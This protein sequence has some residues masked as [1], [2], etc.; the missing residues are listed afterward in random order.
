M[1][2]ELK[3]DPC[4]GQILVGSVINGYRLTR[5]IGRGGMGS[6][7]AAELTLRD[8]SSG[9]ATQVAVKVLH[10]RLAAVDPTAV[11]RFINEA[12]S[13][14]RMNHP[15]L[16]KVLDFGYIESGSVYIMMEFLAGELLRE[17]IRKRAPLPLLESCRIGCQIAEA[18]SAAHD[19]GIVHR[20]V[21]ELDRS[22]RRCS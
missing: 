9:A 13:T 19:T 14:A 11:G 7:F 21:Y 20:E 1:D 3:T 4:S 8:S 6:V 10:E 2:S 16:V 18:M 22:R 12:R 15:G 17:R 5:L